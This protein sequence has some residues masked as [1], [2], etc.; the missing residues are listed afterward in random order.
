MPYMITDTK[1]RS[2]LALDVAMDKEPIR[3]RP[4]VSLENARDVQQWLLPRV[5][6]LLL[7]TLSVVGAGY[8]FT[9]VSPEQLN[10]VIL[11]HWRLPAALMVGSVVGSLC[12]FLSRQPRLSLWV[13]LVVAVAAQLQI[14]RA[15]QMYIVVL[16]LMMLFGTMEI[17]A[18]YF[19]PQT[20]KQP[21]S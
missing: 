21:Q 12:G 8:F 1:A 7:L 18:K 14:L 5:P 11:P 19:L 17:S 15:T 13:V 6:W 4:R 2:R 10:S 3:S 9:Q 16:P 20:K